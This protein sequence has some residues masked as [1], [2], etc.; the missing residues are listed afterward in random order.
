MSTDMSGVCFSTMRRGWKRVRVWRRQCKGPLGRGG[1]SLCLRLHL[2]AATL[3]EEEGDE[4]EPAVLVRPGPC[5]P[6]PTA[7]VRS[8]GRGLAPRAPS[9]GGR[10]TPACAGR[11]GGTPQA[12]RGTVGPAPSGETAGVRGLCSCTS[13]LLPACH[14]G[15]GVSSGVNVPLALPGARTSGPP[16]AGRAGSAF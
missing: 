12:W 15:K 5:V 11:S 4:P 3:R 13:A 7:T 9:P 8:G 6:T 10:R 2:K 14:C 16:R 1:P